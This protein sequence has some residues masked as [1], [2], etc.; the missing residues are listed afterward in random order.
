M[1]SA[2]SGLRTDRVKVDA[3]S[4][5]DATKV[6]Q[7]PVVRVPGLLW[8]R[9]AADGRCRAY[10]L[11]LTHLGFGLL[12]IC[13]TRWVHHG[14]GFGSGA[15]SVLS[16]ANQDDEAVTGATRHCCN[17]QE[18]SF[19]GAADGYGSL[20]RH[21]IGTL[22]LTNTNCGAEN[23]LNLEIIN[24]GST[25]YNLRCLPTQK[26]ETLEVRDTCL[27]V[28]LWWLCSCDLSVCP[29]SWVGPTSSLAALCCHFSLCNNLLQAP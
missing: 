3:A 8:C 16:S 19:G 4:I 21:T 27:V 7:V 10:H 13:P 15:V 2:I 23:E 17:L 18:L 26:S 29:A 5:L 20:S 11:W 1:V 12:H 6:S 14:C 25:E 22:T 9:W 28:G 24:D